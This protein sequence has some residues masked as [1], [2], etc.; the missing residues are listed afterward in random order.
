MK[1]IVFL[2]IIFF[3]AIFVFNLKETIIEPLCKF[4]N[5]SD[6]SSSFT[7]QNK[8]IKLNESV[9]G[10]IDKKISN[11]LNSLKK[12]Q[13]LFNKN[14]KDMSINEK[15]ILRM[16]SSASGKMSDNSAAC[17]KYPEAC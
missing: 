15:N 6:D 8:Q 12:K 4:E 9:S 17:A 11:L 3:L 16:K 7:C 5:K 14:Q 2:T 13:T 1:N 10:Q